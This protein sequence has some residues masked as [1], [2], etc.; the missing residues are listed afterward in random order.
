MV[1]LTSYEGRGLIDARWIRE[2]PRILKF[3]RATL[4]FWREN[5]FMLYGIPETPDLYILRSASSTSDHS[6]AEPSCRPSVNTP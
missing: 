6:R 2:T 3:E 5:T 4:E 1:D